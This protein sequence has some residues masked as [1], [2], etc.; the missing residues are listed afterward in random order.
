MLSEQGYDVVVSTQIKPK[1]LPGDLVVAISGIIRASDI[2]LEQQPKVWDEI[3][4]DISKGA[5]C[6]VLAMP[7]PLGPNSPDGIEV[8][9]TA[10]SAKATL[11]YANSGRANPV[12]TGSSILTLWTNPV[13]EE[14]VYAQRVGKGTCITVV[15]G[16]IATNRHIARQDNASFLIGLVSKLAKKGG[17]VV[18]A[19]ATFGNVSQD[20]VLDVIGPWAVGVYWQCLVLLGAIIFSLGSRFGHPTETSPAERGGR[21]MVNALK[22]L[23]RRANANSASLSAVEADALRRIDR[24]LGM[25]SGIS[26]NDR[27][28]RLPESLALAL[29]NLNSLIEGRPGKAESLRCVE[30]LQRELQSFLEQPW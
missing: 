18:F 11:G 5:T 12:F 17:R 26:P 15:A 13:K 23:Y 22:N 14:I 2:E 6:L 9:S 3:G 24:A 8:R 21:D 20:N 30:V 19:E 25:P 27:N 10:S 16:E 7:S 28:R 1:V 29:M 4:E